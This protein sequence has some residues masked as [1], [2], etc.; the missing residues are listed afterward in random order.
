MTKE[1]RPKV[2]VPIRKK[3][4]TSDM[5]AK[6]LKWKEGDPPQFLVKSEDHPGFYMRVSK[7]NTKAWLVFAF[8]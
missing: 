1:L 8:H 7:G 5:V 6:S 2:K 4:L 3:N